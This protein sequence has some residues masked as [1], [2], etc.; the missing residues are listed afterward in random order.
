MLATPPQ[1]I[2]N[3]QSMESLVSGPGAELAHEPSAAALQAGGGHGS[4]TAGPMALQHQVRQCTASG[5][6]CT[7]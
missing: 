3:S 7:F 5:T 1:P 2:H 6:T 4:L